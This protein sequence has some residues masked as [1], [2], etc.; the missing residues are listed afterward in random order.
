MNEVEV[1][2]LD[3]TM[4]IPIEKLK[5]FKTL[6]HQFEDGQLLSPGESCS[7]PL[8][9]RM[10]EIALKVDE[11]LIKSNDPKVLMQMSEKHFEVLLRLSDYLN[12]DKY[13]WFV[14]IDFSKKLRMKQ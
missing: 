11:V 9:K 6:W 2:F 12:Y 10:L 5:K 14:N 7:V 8:K 4:K 1:V 13:E 3:G